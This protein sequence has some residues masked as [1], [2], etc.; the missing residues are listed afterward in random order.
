MFVAKKDYR[1][2]EALYRAAIRMYTETQGPEHLNT[3]IARLKL[4]RA[5]LRQSRFRDA[6]PETLAGY[7]IVSRQT[8]PSVSFLRAGREDLAAIYEAT[9]RPAEAAKYRAEPS[10]P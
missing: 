4:G 5:L 3:G 1:R 7:A 6:E 9:N 8:T 2:A 10:T